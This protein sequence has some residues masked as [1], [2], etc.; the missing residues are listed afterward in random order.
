MSLYPSGIG[1]V[2]GCSVAAAIVPCDELLSLPLIKNS[3]LH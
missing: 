3:T 2:G 1:V